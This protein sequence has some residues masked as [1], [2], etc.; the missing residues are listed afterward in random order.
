[1]L[2]GGITGPHCNAGEGVYMQGP[3]P[4]VGGLDARLTTLKLGSPRK[5]NPDGLPQEKPVNIL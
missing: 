2:P 3:E 5:C 4:P 1:M